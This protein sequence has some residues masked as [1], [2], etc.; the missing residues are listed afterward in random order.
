[1]LT[2]ISLAIMGAVLSPAHAAASPSTDA[3]QVYVEIIVKACPADQPE[4][5][6]DRPDAVQGYY[7]EPIN[8]GATYDNE[9]SPNSGRA[10]VGLCDDALHRRTGAAGGRRE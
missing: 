8:Q 5:Q 2:E 10:R 4:M 6:A 1:M 7:V 3:P 9:R